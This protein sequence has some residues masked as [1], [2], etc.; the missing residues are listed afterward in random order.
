MSINKLLLVGLFTY[1]FDH[2]H[3]LY[4]VQ[5]NTYLN[6]IIQLHAYIL[7]FLKKYTQKSEKSEKREEII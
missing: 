2:C 5:Y 1:I 6:N 7:L 4:F 3:S